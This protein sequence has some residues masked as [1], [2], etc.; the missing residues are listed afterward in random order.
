MFDRL[1]LDTVEVRPGQRSLSLIWFDL[2]NTSEKIIWSDY[3]HIS[4][5][6]LVPSAV[7]LWQKRPAMESPG[8]VWR[9]IRRIVFPS[10]TLNLD[11]TVS[12]TFTYTYKAS[13]LDT[14]LF[15]MD[16]QLPAGLSIQEKFS[17]PQ[18]NFYITSGLRTPSSISLL[19]QM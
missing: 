8:L 11:C 7:Y 2:R 16:R 10:L 19:L 4:L 3:L 17:I 15:L 6:L 13:G 5:G 12:S 1:T 18:I 14:K 9:F